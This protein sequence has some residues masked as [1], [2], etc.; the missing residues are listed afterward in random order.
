[1]QL[2]PKQ[3]EIGFDL[4][5]KVSILPHTTIF[6]RPLFGRARSILQVPKMSRSVRLVRPGSS[7][8]VDI[9]ERHETGMKV[10]QKHNLH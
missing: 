5:A 10:F 4:I 6:S 7:R 8:V 1:M 3:G 2:A 9:T